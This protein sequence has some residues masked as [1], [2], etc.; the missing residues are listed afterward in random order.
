VRWT[1]I[2]LRL[3]LIASLFGAILCNVSAWITAPLGL[4]S[5][6]A[7]S[8][9]AV[10]PYA[11]NAADRLLLGCGATVTTFIIIGLGLNLTPWGLART[12]WSVT[13]LVISIGVLIRRRRVRTRIKRLPVAGFWSLIPW[14]V[15]ASLILIV[16]VVLALAGV[17]DWD[18]K[19]V[20][21]FSVV[22]M[23]RDS[24]VVEIEAT[25]ITGKYRIMATSNTQKALQYSSPLLTIRA[26]GSEEQVRERVLLNAAG[27]WTIDLQSADSGTVVRWVK[28]D[29]TH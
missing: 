5:I 28:V 17:R 1:E 23:S 4:V 22:S 19:P 14:M 9:L 10:R 25:S 6:A 21:A 12:T 7:T 2:A 8:E 15:F 26:G 11:T 29:L 16:A 20:L 24:A 3:A 18:E 13:W 27:T